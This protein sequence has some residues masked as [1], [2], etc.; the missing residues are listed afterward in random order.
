MDTEHLEEVMDDLRN[1]VNLIER[2]I[3]AMAS[4]IRY[5]ESSIDDLRRDISRLELVS[6]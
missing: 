5:L 2:R 6:R 4:D 1:S 3:D